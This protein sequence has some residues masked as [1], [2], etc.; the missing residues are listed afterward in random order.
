MNYKG[1][2]AVV[3]FDDE[4]RLFVGRVINTRDVIVFD[5]LSVDELEQSFQAVIDE[6]L[7]DCESLGK[8][9]DKPF[10]GRFN[11]RISSELHRKAATKAIQEGVSLNTLVE[12]ALQ[13]I[14]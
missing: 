9:P 2:E 10:S 1:Y 12:Q 6:Y 3:E 8:T 7:E 14:L 4:D 13:K 11:L 5:G